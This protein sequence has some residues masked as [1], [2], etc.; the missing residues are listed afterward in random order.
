MAKAFSFSYIFHW[1]SPFMGAFEIY[2]PV[3]L[4]YRSSL[5]CRIYYSHIRV[6]KNKPKLYAK[7]LQ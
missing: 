1:R 6:I 3:I 2:I 5:W 4:A 7:T